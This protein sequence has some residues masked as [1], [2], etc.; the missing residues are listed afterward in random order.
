MHDMKTLQFSPKR[1]PSDEPKFAAPGEF[2][3]WATRA[4]VWRPPTDVFDNGIAIV[5]QIEIAGM[6]DAEFTISLEKDVLAIRGV[7]SSLATE[8]RAYYQMEIPSGEFVS[9]VEL[10]QLIDYDNIEANY[11][12]G[13]LRVVLPKAQPS[14]VPVDDK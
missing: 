12:D 9:M 1:K 3:Q 10:P 2:R 13:F 5:V 11:L 6:R 4:Q 8:Q 7:R 14:R